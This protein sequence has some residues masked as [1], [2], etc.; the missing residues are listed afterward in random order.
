MVSSPIASSITWPARRSNVQPKPFNLLWRSSWCR[1]WWRLYNLPFKLDTWKSLDRSNRNTW[2]SDLSLSCPFFKYCVLALGKSIW[3]NPNL[4]IGNV[5]CLVG[6]PYLPSW[7]LGGKAPLESGNRHLIFFE[8]FD[9]IRDWDQESNFWMIFST[10]INLGSLYPP[11]NV[12]GSPRRR[13]ALGRRSRKREGREGNSGYTCFNQ[14]Y[15]QVAII[16][17]DVMVW[18][19]FKKNNFMLYSGRYKK[20][21]RFFLM[22]DFL[23]CLTVFFQDFIP[24]AGPPFLMEID[25]KGPNQPSPSPPR[26]FSRSFLQH[27]EPQHACN[28]A[29]NKWWST[30]YLHFGATFIDLRLEV[31]EIS[32]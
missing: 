27:S 1:W 30:Q 18:W 22:V 31:R 16:Q 12:W 9:T 10:K 4:C 24:S 7:T 23:L 8:Y 5:L 21:G 17:V 19:N 32:I 6:F 28:L 26:S 2:N 3:T 20:R 13:G 11:W 15:P 25:P 29:F 14:E